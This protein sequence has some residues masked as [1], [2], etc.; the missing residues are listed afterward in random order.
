M[1][2]KAFL[3]KV[4]ELP[5]YKA[6]LELA[7]LLVLAIHWLVNLGLTE[8]I[9]LVKCFFHMSEG[10]LSKEVITNFELSYLGDSG[11]CGLFF[12]ILHLIML[13]LKGN[14]YEFLLHFWKFDTDSIKPLGRISLSSPNLVVVDKNF[15]QEASKVYDRLWF[16]KSWLPPQGSDS[17]I[18]PTPPGTQPCSVCQRPGME[19]YN[20][21]DRREFLD[22]PVVEADFAKWQVCKRWTCNLSCNV[23]RVIYFP[24]Y[25]KIYI[26]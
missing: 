10:N 20:Y 11:A 5:Q 8:L 18:K 4:K 9:K 26:T 19:Y 13:C 3:D 15:V 21:L 12:E 2:G 1:T 7:T 25:P 23:G 14:Y 6:L 16:S 17:C 22:I 24:L